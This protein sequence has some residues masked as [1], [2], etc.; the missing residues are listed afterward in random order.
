MAAAAQAYLGVALAVLAVGA[1]LTAACDPVRLGLSPT[2]LED[3]RRA[4]LIGLL[5]LLSLGLV[6]FRMI[7]EACQKGYRVNLLLTG[8]AL[9]ITGVSLLL[10]RAGW[11]ITGQ[12]IAFVLGTWAFSLVLA[13]A[14]VVCDPSP[15][16]LRSWTIRPDPETPRALCGAW[17][18]RRS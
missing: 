5:G 4:W 1:A 15:A 9:L 11:G 13:V 10:A 3:L 7:V 8:Q 16:L 14:G 2:D 12:S 18:R 17:A 6:P